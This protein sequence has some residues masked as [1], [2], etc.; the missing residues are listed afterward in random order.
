MESTTFNPHTHIPPRYDLFGYL[1]PEYKRK[2]QLGL[3]EQKQ[4]VPV[5]WNKNTNE[6]GATT[7]KE[8]I[9][10]RKKERLPDISFDL[11]GDGYVGGRDYFIAKLYDKDGDG[12]LNDKERKEAFEGLANGIEDKFMWNVTNPITHKRCPSAGVVKSTAPIQ[13]QNKKTQSNNDKVPTTQQ[14]MSLPSK[15]IQSYR[16]YMQ[17]RGKILEA[18]NFLPVRE[19]YPE[20]PISKVQPNVKTYN[21]LKQKRK[22]NNLNEINIA[23]QNWEKRNP[24]FIGDNYN[25]FTEPNNKSFHSSRSEIRLKHHKESRIK[26]G[27]NPEESGTGECVK[28]APSLAYIYNPKHKTKTDIV[29]E[30]KTENLEQHSK[31]QNK[32]HKNEIERLDDRENEIFDKLYSDNEGKTYSAI[33]AKQRQESN[34]TNI[35]KFSKQTLGVHGHELPKFSQSKTMKEFWKHKDDYCKDPKYKSQVEYKESIKYWKPSEELLLNEHRDEAPQS[36]DPFKKEYHPIDKTKED[37]KMILKVNKLNHFRN[38]DPNVHFI[39]D[40][41]APSKHIYRWTTLVNQF[42]PNK[43][44][45]GRFFDTIPNRDD[46]NKKSKPQSG[47][48]NSKDDESTVQKESTKKEKQ[49]KGTDY[50]VKHLRNKFK[51]EMNWIKAEYEKAEFYK[52]AK[53]SLFHKFSAKD[54]SKGNIPKGAIAR[55]KGF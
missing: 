22:Q 15:E 48:T 3:L 8:L 23:V 50:L 36:V 17:V 39:F 11:D 32:Q 2:D 30:I 52:T 45:E 33:K 43:F 31:L 1:Q 7:R 42:A 53:D 29:N 37:K 16:H 47:K 9:D 44:K 18:E 20:H 6:T 49:F 4:V 19:T 46:D 12:K 25:K 38:F 51:N 10:I 35:K 41:N 28:K 14:P 5:E 27:L 34:E 13:K 55:T 54:S 21:E 26:C 40:V 24:P